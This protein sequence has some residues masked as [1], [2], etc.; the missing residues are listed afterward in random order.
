M[1]SSM[2]CPTEVLTRCRSSAGV[3]LLAPARN[4]RDPAVCRGPAWNAS[5]TEASRVHLM[6]GVAASRRCR[7][8]TAAAR[9][10]RQGRT[11]DGG[12]LA[13]RSRRS[14]SRQTTWLGRRARIGRGPSAPCCSSE[15][16]RCGQAEQVSISCRA[17]PSSTVVGSALR[18]GDAT[19]IRYRADDPPVFVAP[20]SATADR[21]VK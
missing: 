3:A 13:G 1:I 9:R 10:V 4:E 5:S 15:V 17:S 20:A 18:F 6:R 7:R 8:Q 14:M 21:L 16:A 2:Y 11:R 12:A 19:Q